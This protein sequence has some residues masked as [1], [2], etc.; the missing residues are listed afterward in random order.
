MAS[1]ALEDYQI[2]WICALTIE[3]AAAAQEMLM[4]ISGLLK[5]R[6][7]QAQICT[8][9]AELANIFFLLRSQVQRDSMGRHQLLW[10]LLTWCELFPSHHESG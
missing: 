5:S 9:W 7:A 3:A 8:F 10:L 1:P 6:I 2:D 4:R